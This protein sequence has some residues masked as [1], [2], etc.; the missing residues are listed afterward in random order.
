MNTAILNKERSDFVEQLHHEFLYLKGYGAYT[1]I[2]PTDASNL[3]DSYLMHE[4]NISSA[5]TQQQ[6]QISF[7]R[8]FIRKI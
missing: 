7:I 2:S 5:I 4:N 1:Y 6:A 3:F 8:A